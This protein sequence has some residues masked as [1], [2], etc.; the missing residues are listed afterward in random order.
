[1]YFNLD[2]NIMEE[3]RTFENYSSRNHLE[4]E[5][6]EK[7]DNNV[8]RIERTLELD[9]ETPLLKEIEPSK[10]TR[11]GDGSVRLIFH[12]HGEHVI[13]HEKPEQQHPLSE[14][15]YEEMKKIG[16]EINV[17]ESQTIGFYTD[18][19][20]SLTSVVAVMNPSLDRPNPDE[21]LRKK[22]VKPLEALQYKVVNDRVFREKL[23]AAVQKNKVL[24]F[25]VNESDK[26]AGENIDSLSTYSSISREIGA[27]IKRYISVERNWKKLTERSPQYA[28]KDLYRLFCGREFIYGCFRAKLTEQM[29]GEEM[30][31]RFV[32]WYEASREG[33]GLE[34]GKM[35]TIKLSVDAKTDTLKGSLTDSFGEVI[36]TEEIINNIMKKEFVAERMGVYCIPARKKTAMDQIEIAVVKYSDGFGFVGGGLKKGETIEDAMSRELKE[37]LGKDTAISMTRLKKIEGVY[38]FEMGKEKRPGEEAHME[39][40]KFYLAKLA[41]DKSLSFA[42]EGAEITWLPLQ[43]L[44]SPT[45]TKYEDLRSFLRV[46]VIPAIQKLFAEKNE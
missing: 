38:V 35:G 37:E 40:H 31:D 15:G 13:I 44:L 14:A 12:R 22:R 9:N 7:S 23:D 20:R 36:F 34:R 41:E 25:L 26:I 18:N 27:T 1:M 4:N 19:L 42:E 16:R 30:R 32:E 21:Y 46:N 29:F 28:K 17:I 6:G 45:V 39:R 33:N 2:Q 8:V 3:F 24:H 11:E 5:E 43:D 10:E